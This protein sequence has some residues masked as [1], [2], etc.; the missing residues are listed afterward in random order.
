VVTGTTGTTAAVT[1]GTTATATATCPAGKL[2]LGGGGTITATVAGRAA[3]LQSRPI[4]TTQW[5]V[6][7]VVVTALGAGNTASIQAFALCTA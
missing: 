1:V 2:M 5:Q 3:M 4:S 7:L 6:M